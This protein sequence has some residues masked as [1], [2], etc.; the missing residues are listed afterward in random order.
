MLPQ[1]APRSYQVLFERIRHFQVQQ[2]VNFSDVLVLQ[3][4][5]H[6]RQRRLILVNHVG[7]LVDDFVDGTTPANL[8]VVLLADD[9]RFF[10][11][12]L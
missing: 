3:M 2:S 9:V 8:T 10:R 5:F 6:L 12:H 1:D 7:K 4:F 11:E